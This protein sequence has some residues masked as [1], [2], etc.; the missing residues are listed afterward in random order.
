MAVLRTRLGVGLIS[1]AVLALELTLMRAMALRYWHHFAH[2]IISVALLGFGASGTFLSLLRRPSA[3]GRRGRAFGFALAFAVSV[4]V[5]VL[6]AERVPLDVRLLAWDFSQAGWVLAVEAV[7]LVP[8]FLAAAAICTALMDEAR[9]VSGHYAANLVGSAAGSV[10]A[11]VLMGVLT[12]GQVLSVVAGAALV[13]AAVLAPW[14]RWLAAGAMAAAAG[15][16]AAF[17]LGVRYEP[18]VSPQM[19]LSVVRDMPGTK[20]LAR[21]EGPLG[22]LD[23][24]VNPAFHYAP[25]LSLTWMEPLPEQAVM[26]LNG[27]TV[28]PVF[29][30][31]RREDW[32]FTDYT[33]AAAAFRVT[34]AGRVLVLGAGGGSGIGLGL[35]HGAERI[36]AVE[37]NPQVVRAMRGPLRGRGGA[38]YDAANVRVE[39]RGVRDVLAALPAEAGGWDVILLGPAGGTGA[40]A[41]G[42]S[43][44]YTVEAFE[45]MLGRLSRG[46]VLCMTSP[47]WSPPRAGLRVFDTAAEALRRRGKDPRGHLAMIRSWATVTV[48][49]SSGPWTDEQAARIEAF[50]EARSFDLCYVPGLARGQAN[51]FHVLDRPAFFEAAGAL[52]SARRRAFLDAYLYDVEAATD[53]RPFF[54]HTFRWRALAEIRAQRGEAGA[55]GFVEMGYLMLLAALGQGAVLA[56]VLVLLPLA[57]RRGGGGRGGRAATLAYFLLLGAG[58]MLLEMAFLQKLILYLAHPIYSAAVVIAGFLVFAG[59]GSEVSR[60]WPGGGRRVIGCAAGAVVGLAVACVVALDAW[61]GWTQGSA[62]GVRVGVALATIAPIAFA[63]G[64]LFPTGLRALS[65]ARPGLVPWAWAVNGFASVLASVAAP[66]VA[67]E[68]GFTGLT[69]VAGACYALAGL[70][71]PRLPSGPEEEKPQ[72]TTNSP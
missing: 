11:V 61:L 16:L 36:T 30:C 62:F 56:T 69:A 54:G 13:A 6:A 39:Q 25:W 3:A 27:D 50:C 15:G 42:E 28:V 53:D 24:A 57:V 67:M 14:R 68:I 32:R 71:G 49:A 47:A 23:A 21:S 1:M 20:F 48:L 8:F 60:R 40:G 34:G 44:V 45:A 43:Y 65:S 38:V 66:L 63:M 10:G 4:P 33:T 72:R 64:H 46:G 59:A 29:D 9:H 31:R 2:M 5:A 35:Y 37:P 12:A 58:F 55:R 70:V 17:V 52:L 19:T 7:L 26:I 18:R 41:V 22:R 51:R